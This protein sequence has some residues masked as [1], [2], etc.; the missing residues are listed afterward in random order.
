MINDGLYGD[1]AV[2]AESA[3]TV[4]TLLANNEVTA[5]QTSTNLSMCRHYIKLKKVDGAL[6]DYEKAS[7]ISDWRNA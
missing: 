2:F 1:S 4:T 6:F 3:P 7:L 5:P